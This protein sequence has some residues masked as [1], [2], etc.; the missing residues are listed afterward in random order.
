MLAHADEAALRRTAQ[1]GF[2]HFYSRSRERVWKK[3]EESGNTLRVFEIW[4]DCDADAVVYLVEPAGPTCHTGNESCFSLRVHP[5]PEGEDDRALPVLSRLERDVRQR[6]ESTAAKS[7]TRSLLDAGATRIGEKLRE[8][9]GELG[10]AIEE[11]TDARVVS[12]AADLVYHIM[13]GLLHRDIPF[14]DVVAELAR[15]SGT[16]GHEEKATR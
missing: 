15:R 4:L 14:R 1:S 9:A 3:G 11:E 7:Y 10:R 13:V 16:S 8:E 2:A 12:E 5:E 6:R